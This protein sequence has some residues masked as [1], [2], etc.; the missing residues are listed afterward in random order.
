[1]KR[2]IFTVYLVIA[3]LYAFAQSFEGEIVYHNTYKSK[4]PAVNDTKLSGMMGTAENYYIKDGDYRSETNGS[5]VLW[6]LYINADNKLYSK[7]TS[8]ETV[9]WNDGSVKNDA[10]NSAE[11]HYDAAVIS[12]YHC[13]ELI[14]NCK[15]G[16]EKYYFSSKLPIDSRLYAKHQFGNWY[17][18]LS[19]ANAVPLKMIIDN[20]QFTLE[21]TATAIKPMKLEKKR[22][23]LPAGVKI[24]PMK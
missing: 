4:I 5:L 8:S 13:D 1:M 2:I 15:S 21:S 20:A 10:V 9:L 11:L 6:Q 23:E 22:F 3:C 7:Y 24:A 17:A 19:K 18:Y 14:L 16:V 12:G